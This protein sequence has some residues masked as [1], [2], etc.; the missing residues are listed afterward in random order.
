MVH[1]DNAR[2]HNSRK[3]N[4]ALRA[5]KA[6]RIPA[7]AY[8]PDLSP[9][10]FFLFE[11]LQER[12]SGSSYSSPDDLISA[13]GEVIASILQDELVRVYENLVKRLRWVIAYRGEY[14][15]K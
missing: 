1:L 7:P 6:R 10:D 15:H 8:S 11:M 5:I 4:E 13:I 2:P 12:L 9:S 14:Y 3:R